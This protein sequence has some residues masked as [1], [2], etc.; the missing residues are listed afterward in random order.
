MSTF[1]ERLRALRKERGINQKDFAAHLNISERSLQNYETDERDPKL[2]FIKD[3]AN[4][5]NVNSAYLIGDSSDPTPQTQSSEA[6]EMSPEELEFRSWAQENLVSSFFYDLDKNPDRM[7]QEMWD[8][9]RE[10]WKREKGRK[11][12]QKQGE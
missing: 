12:G 3:C 4:F 2:T 7:K 6:I 10:V 1:G 5:L 9:L 8:A 11:P